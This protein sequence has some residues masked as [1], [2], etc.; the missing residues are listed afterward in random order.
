MYDTAGNVWEWVEDCWHVDY[1][2]APT[3]GSAWVDGDCS[4]R[5]L[6]GG[7]WVVVPRGVRSANRIWLDPDFREDL[8]VGF[9]VARAPD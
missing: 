1:E 6:R 5:V 8:D 3:D 7:A 4:T 2:G 9:R